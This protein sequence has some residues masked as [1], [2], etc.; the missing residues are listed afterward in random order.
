MKLYSFTAN[1]DEHLTNAILDSLVI[2][3]DFQ[4]FYLPK[5]QSWSSNLILASYTSPTPGWWRYLCQLTH[6]CPRLVCM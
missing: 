3:P 2:I 6:W 5:A 1:A 4:S